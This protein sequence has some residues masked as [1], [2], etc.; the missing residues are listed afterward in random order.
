MINS[1]IISTRG[2]HRMQM[3]GWVTKVSSILCVLDQ[4]KSDMFGLLGTQYIWVI[5]GQMYLGHNRSNLLANTAWQTCRKR[6]LGTGNLPVAGM[7]IAVPTRAARRDLVG[8]ANILGLQWS[9][10]SSV[11]TQQCVHRSSPTSQGYS[12]WSV[13]RY[14]KVY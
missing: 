11:E 5:K 9:L 8:F 12:G 1:L 4:V 14:T 13:S 7:W 6:H 3:I 2:I 10:Q